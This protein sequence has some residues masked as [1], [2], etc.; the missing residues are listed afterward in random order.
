MTNRTPYPEELTAPI[1]DAWAD[2]ADA[3]DALDNLKAAVR[4]LLEQATLHTP[5][6]S[7]SLSLDGPVECGRYWKVADLVGLCST[8]LKVHADPT[9]GSPWHP[10]P[11]HAKTQ[12]AIRKLWPG[13]GS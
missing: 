3:R 8:D 12:A 11:L 10:Q 6:L 9:D 4:E 2:A 13:G 7:I 1:A 5:G